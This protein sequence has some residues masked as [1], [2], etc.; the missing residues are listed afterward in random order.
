MGA[1][2]QPSYRC[3]VGSN[4]KPRREGIETGLKGLSSIQGDHMRVPARSSTMSR[5]R[6]P[7]PS[8]TET[9]PRLPRAADLAGIVGL[10]DEQVSAIINATR[11]LNPLDRSA[12]LQALAAALRGHSEVG[13]GELHRLL[14]TL[15]RSHFKPPQVEGERGSRWA[16]GA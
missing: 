7:P 16:R 6:R 12:F 15:Q 1:S 9:L 11:P 10:S 5:G 3:Y 14:A 2:W 4:K 8:S 13:S